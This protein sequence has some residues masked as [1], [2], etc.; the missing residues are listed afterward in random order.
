VKAVPIAV[1]LFAAACTSVVTPP[2]NPID[3]V[4]VYLVESE[5]HSG[6]VL[7]RT[8]DEYVEYGY[9]DWDWFAMNCT[10]WYYVFDTILW[11]T[12]G[13]LGRRILR[14]PELRAMGP[15]AIRVSR[16]DVE[17]LLADLDRRY[18][19]GRETEVYN[20][21]MRM[22]FVKVDEGF[23]F[24]HTCADA[25]AGWLRRLGCSVSAAPIRSG[26]RLSD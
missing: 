3:P 17:G 2:E 25:T 24:G 15:R 8:S 10:A 13:T 9:G 21:Q 1:L 7:P 11:P 6:L 16:S 14:E 18:E 12:Q 22:H 5:L 19:A 4:E 23:W 20:E 26:L